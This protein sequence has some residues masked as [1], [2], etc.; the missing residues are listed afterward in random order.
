MNLDQWL[1]KE[2]KVGQDI[3]KNKYQQ[4][5]ETLDEW[6]ER[7]SNKN[8]EVKRLMKE[9]KF[10]FGGRVLAGRNINSKLSYSNCY[11][12]QSPKDNL[13]DILR[14]CSEMARTYSY[15]GGCGIDISKLRPNGSKVNN[16]AK[17]SSGAISFMPLFSKVTETICQSG[18]RK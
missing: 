3:W 9:K 11:V 18:R 14:T 5:N 12:I 15:G 13:E 10:L 17:V 1:G 7:I 16:A 8:E 4:N 2:N 6:F